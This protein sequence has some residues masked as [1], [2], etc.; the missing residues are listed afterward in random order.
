[1]PRKRTAKGKGSDAEDRCVAELRAAGYNAWR[2]HMSKGPCDVIAWNDGLVRLIQ[3]KSY[4]TPY[5]KGGKK[6]I[7][8][9]LAAL[10]RPPCATVELWIWKGA[11]DGHWEDR[12][13]C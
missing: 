6:T 3:V 11:A 10:P 8:A 4:T 12:R 9:E 7:V 5:F 1:M 13:T 2:T